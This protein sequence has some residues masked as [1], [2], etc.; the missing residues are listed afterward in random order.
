M[1]EF[2]SHFNA[3]P[4][5]VEVPPNVEDGLQACW[6]VQGLSIRHGQKQILPSLFVSETTRNVCLAFSPIHSAG[7]QN[8]NQT[9]NWELGKG[10]GGNSHDVK[11]FV[12][13]KIA[14][15]QWGL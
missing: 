9:L 7:L 11:P 3:P 1:V 8:F 15:W 10:N 13:L 14:L 4:G 5:N 12:L 6:Q 2:P